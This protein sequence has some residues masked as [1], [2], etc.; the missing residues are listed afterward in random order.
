M[1]S[2]IKR[3]QK[4]TQPTMAHSSFVSS[5]VLVLVCCVLGLTSGGIVHHEPGEIQKSFN[6][7][8]LLNNYVVPPPS[9]NKTQIHIV[10]ECPPNVM[11]VLDGSGSISFAGFDNIKQAVVREIRALMAAFAQVDVGIV[12]FR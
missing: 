6:L 3:H 8:H 11:F 12:V 10:T 7:F 1:A 4:I 2:L 9:S 5:L